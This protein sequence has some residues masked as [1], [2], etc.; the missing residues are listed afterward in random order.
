MLAVQQILQ[1]VAQLATMMVVVLLTIRMMVGGLYECRP[2]AKGC[3]S[4]A[5]KQ[6]STNL[7]GDNLE[8]EF[9]CGSLQTGKRGV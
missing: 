3:H 9:E 5:R 2:K 7:L 8:R 6:T 4:G 1:T